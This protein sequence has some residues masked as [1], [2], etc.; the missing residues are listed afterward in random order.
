MIFGIKEEDGVE[1]EP[2]ISF[3]GQRSPNN[4]MFGISLT[5]II[6]TTTLCIA[7]PWIC[8]TAWI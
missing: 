3:F 4:V 8:C 2:K 7:M 1:D 5:A 6:T